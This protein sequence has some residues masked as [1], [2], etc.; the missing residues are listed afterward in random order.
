MLN[1]SRNKLVYSSYIRFD[2]SGVVTNPKLYNNN[3]EFMQI[4]GRKHKKQA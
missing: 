1:K 2:K 4:K 3:N